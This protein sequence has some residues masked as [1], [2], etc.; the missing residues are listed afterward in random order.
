MMHK[1]TQDTANF[2]EFFYKIS[3]KVTTKIGSPAEQLLCVLGAAGKKEE[4][5]NGKKKRRN[6]GKN[7]R[8]RVV[9]LTLFIEERN[10]ALHILYGRIV[11]G[12][13]QLLDDL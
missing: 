7:A 10:D 11:R 3:Y 13:L 6:E 9:L 1:D 2:F 12:L 5:Q 4:C 8:N